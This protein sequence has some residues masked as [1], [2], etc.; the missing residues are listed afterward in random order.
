MERE[1]DVRRGD[2]GNERDRRQT[3]RPGEMVCDLDLHRLAGNPAK[4]HAAPRGARHRESRGTGRADLS[5]HKGHDPAGDDDGGGYEKNAERPRSG[6]PVSR[7]HLRYPPG[8]PSGFAMSG[9]TERTARKRSRGIRTGRGGQGVL[10]EL[11]RR[12][13]APRV[14]AMTR[15]GYPA[16]PDTGRRYGVRRYNR[17]LR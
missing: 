14:I 6:S 8:D 7:L 1:R 11:L 3:D 4:G 10:R 13:P 15:A 2:P 17:T 5:S 9:Q 12:P 16:G